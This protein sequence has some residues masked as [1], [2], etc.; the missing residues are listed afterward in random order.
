MRIEKYLRAL[1]FLTL[2][3]LCL[4][5]IGCSG[6]VW[7]L[8]KAIVTGY[9]NAGI[10]DSSEDVVRLSDA[11]YNEIC[12]LFESDID[13]IYYREA[14]NRWNH[15]EQIL[16][17]KFGPEKTKRADKTQWL[18]DP[19]PLAI[20]V[21]LDNTSS[22]EGYINH[23]HENNKTFVNVFHAIDNFQYRCSEQKIATDTI[24]GYYTQRNKSTKSDEIVFFKW[25]TMKNQLDQNRI[26]AFTDSYQ[27]DNFL[28]HIVSRMETDIAHRHLSFFITDGIP[29]GSNDEVTGTKWNLNN[30]EELKKRIRDIA[31]RMSENNFGISIYQFEGDF[32]NGK[33]WYYDNDSKYFTERNKKV[34]PFYVIVLGDIEVVNLFKTEVK[35]HLKLFEPKD[36]HQLHYA[37]PVEEISMQ[38]KSDGQI[39]NESN[40]GDFELDADGKEFVNV[41]ISIPLGALPFSMHDSETLSKAIILK[42]EDMQKDV[43]PKIKDGQVVYDN[44]RLNTLF[45]HVELE[46]NN[47]IPSWA[48]EVNVPNDKTTNWNFKG[49]FNFIVLAEGL[50]EGFSGNE[51]YVF[52]PIRKTIKINN[53]KQ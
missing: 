20:D 28:D 41:S 17:D 39:A 30:T 49:T 1:N 53:L 26:N 19:K 22:M 46:M 52:D 15:I 4:V 38:V 31:K 11:D 37:N 6:T 25:N 29:S 35:K 42:I 45:N 8:E 24:R 2:L 47:T 21:Y 12:A 3:T 32:Y 13:S 50:K 14:I 33:Y 36:N 34:R 9:T 43:T 18:G 10:E 23:D 27:L 40:E 51:D 44:I 48:V 16:S 5:F 7:Y